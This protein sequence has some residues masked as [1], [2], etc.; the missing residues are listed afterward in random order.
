MR[1]TPYGY[2]IVDGKA[3]VNEEKAEQIRKICENYL[4]GMS[5]MAAAEYVGL[6][7]SHCGVKRM[8]QNER[9]L[10]DEFYPAILTREI[11]DQIEKERM[12]RE[13]MLGRNDRVKKSLPEA[14]VYIGFTALKIALKFK[15][16]IRQA[17]Y[18]YSQIRNEVSS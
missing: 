16:Q 4:G 3:V 2:D 8:I 17:E 12:R 9:Y 1:H 11:A 13:K 5:F 15:D 10:G 6:S 18:A 14:K 7:M